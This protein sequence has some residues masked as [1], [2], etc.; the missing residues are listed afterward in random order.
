MQVPQK[1]YTYQAPSLYIFLFYLVIS[2]WTIVSVL[3]L[4]LKYQETGIADMTQLLILVFLLGMTWYFSLGISYRIKMEE[5]GNIELK[6]LRRVIQTNPQ[7]INLVQGPLLPV[8]FLRIRLE[9][10]KVYLFCFATDQTIHQ[11]LS[12]IRSKNP[13]IKFKSM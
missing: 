8:G 9:R 12:L 10:E 6:S 5:N 2:A 4:G 7:R 3:F 13:D 11:I 1:T